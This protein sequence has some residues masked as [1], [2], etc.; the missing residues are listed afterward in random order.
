MLLAHITEQRAINGRAELL[1][2]V[3]RRVS[4]VH[5][6]PEGVVILAV[7]DLSHVHRPHKAHGHTVQGF[8]E[9]STL[10]PG[11]V[12]GD[13][14]QEQMRLVRLALGDPIALV[15]PVKTARQRVK[16][17]AALVVAAQAD[18]AA[19]VYISGSFVG[20]QGRPAFAH[21]EFVGF[22]G[23]FHQARA[24]EN[25]LELA[26]HQAL[27]HVNAANQ[28]FL[29]GG[30]I[31]AQQARG[32]QPAR[33]GVRQI[34]DEDV[35]GVDPLYIYRSQFQLRAGCV[36]QIDPL[37]HDSSLVHLFFDRYSAKKRQ[38]STD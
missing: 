12:C 20:R 29:A 23:H 19:H 22:L 24:R 9:R 15:V 31:K 32:L 8:I 21:R 2:D 28:I 30:C 25:R 14:A 16:H 10:R 5:R 37:A 3:G 26:R 4:R 38:K 36:V 7:L 6:T 17:L 11:L 1:V 13:Q 18:H 27:A 35:Q 33:I 34:G